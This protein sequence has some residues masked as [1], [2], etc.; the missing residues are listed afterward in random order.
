MN[1]KKST[2]AAVTALSVLTTGLTVTS[3]GK[4]KAE[5]VS[6]DAPWYS[7]TKLEMCEQYIEDESINFYM[8]AFAGMDNDLFYYVSS[9]QYD[10]PEDADYMSI[11]Y[12]ELAFLYLDVYD[13]SGELYKTVNLKDDI[14][15][16]SV[17]PDGQSAPNGYQV[18]DPD[19]I[20]INDG[21]LII[22]IDV[23]LSPSWE[24]HYYY[25]TYDIENETV[26]D[27]ELTLV[28]DSNE[29]Q[30][31]VVLQYYSS[32]SYSFDGY[33]VD[34]FTTHSVDHP[35]IVRVVSPDGT[36]SQYDIEEVLPDLQTP[37]ISEVICQGNDQALVGFFAG[38]YIDKYYYTLDLQAG[39]FT[40][41]TEDTSWFSNYFTYCEA[42]YIEG[43]G[44][45]ITDNTGIKKINF[46][47]N[48]IEE[49]FSYNYCNINRYDT[50]DLSIVSIDDNRIILSGTVS[51]VDSAGFE[52]MSQ[53]IFIL[54]RQESNPH[55]GKQIIKAATLTDFDYTFCEAVVNYNDSSTD[56]YIVLD[57]QYSMLEM[58]LEGEI[59]SY[60]DGFATDGLETQSQVSD[61]LAIDLMSGDGPDI[62][63]DGA[64]FYQL[65]NGEYLMDLSSDI[66]TSS[67]FANIIDSAEVNG[68]L[69]QLP[70]TVG[71]NG[72]VVNTDDIAS[73]QCGFTFEQYASFVSVAC[74]GEDPIDMGKT[75]FFL[76]CLSSLNEECI[77]GS[78]ADYGT[79]SFR[80]LASYVN[81]NV[82]DPVITPEDEI[83]DY[84]SFV[85]TE[86]L[87]GGAYV[88]DISF[89][90]FI[91]DYYTEDIE[92]LT[93]LGIP[94]ADGRGPMI[95]VSSSV[96]I[97]AKTA[98]KDACIDFIRSLISDDVQRDYGIL[99]GSIPV[100]IS[101]FESSSADIL[102]EINETIE[103]NLE[104]E[105]A[106]GFND[107]SMPSSVIDTSVIYNF[108]N[109]INSCSQVASLDPEIMVIIKEEIPAYFAGQKTIDEV[110]S[111]IN[112]RVTT[113]INERG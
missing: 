54:D 52:V 24:D 19:N 27:M 112:D 17:I 10:P 33:L 113:F 36:V 28:D 55:S 90:E 86:D 84:Y 101:A 51:I 104:Y 23:M 68:K 15:I 102:S 44:Y 82:F 3:C 110:I 64:S 14:D 22:L 108:E 43:T 85:G 111:I 98:S 50:K 105:A 66:D 71:I 40:P 8:T 103:L 11:D 75:E 37:E 89:P 47:N 95:T 96:A 31:N 49:I 106:Y 18:M 39:A 83:V 9:G 5:Y 25:V 57:G 93:I 78:S 73:G 32:G 41:Y 60:S 88:Q 77:S 58:Y 56:H 46:E 97:S 20:R 74:N 29:L 45:V 61:K 70:L 76:T 34:A 100:N 1:K 21:K 48:E 42:T 107:P 7:L 62:I 94:S 81:D 80:A 6:D 65:Y 72:I 63:L 13:M 16:S 87:N 12:T 59:R 91:R 30:N 4:K 38:N 35:P 26:T 99:T 67:L 79:D 53:R 69:Y 92:N 2:L 109:I